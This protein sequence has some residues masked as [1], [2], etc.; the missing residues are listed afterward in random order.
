MLQKIIPAHLNPNIIIEI[1]SKENIYAG[2][3]IEIYTELVASELCY[4]TDEAGNY[5]TDEE[6]NRLICSLE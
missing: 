4:L 5:L 3:G 2:A 1:A 6:G